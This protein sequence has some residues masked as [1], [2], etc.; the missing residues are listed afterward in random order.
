MTIDETED[1][2]SNIERLR[3]HLDDDALSAKLVDTYRNNAPEE[4]AAA[5][6]A[7][8]EERLAQIRAAIVSEAK[9]DA[10]D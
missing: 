3:S 2:K 6:K 9:A 7:V 8:A 10:P 1:A 5:L 4:R